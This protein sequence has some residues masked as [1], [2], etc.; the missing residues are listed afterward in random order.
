MHAVLLCEPMYYVL[1]TSA[2]ATGREICSSLMLQQL[3]Y[4]NLFW[5]AAWI[6]AVGVRVHIKVRRQAAVPAH[7][8]L[9]GEGT[10]AVL[11]A[12]S[13]LV[14]LLQLLLVYAAEVQV[15]H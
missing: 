9:C 3:L 2:A 1:H 10:D 14:Q 12:V 4:Y 8:T 13:C 11:R 5:S 7:E 15:L 6:I